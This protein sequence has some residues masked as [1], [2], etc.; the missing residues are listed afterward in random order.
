MLSFIR[1][2]A[3]GWIAWVIVGLLIV[4]FALWGVNEYVG[5]GG[6]LVAA[7]VNG[8]EIGQ[9]EFQQAFYDQRGRMQQMLGGQYD[10]QLFDP[11]IKQRVINELVDRELLLQNADDMGFR[12]S[13]QAVVA[14]IQSIDAFREN[15]V[16]SA[17]LYQQ[18]LQTQGQSPTAFERRV[19][20][21]MT[22]GQLPDGL[23]SSVFVTDAELDAVIKLEKQQRDFQYFVLN[24]S[25][26]QDESLADD[27]AIKDY[28]EQHV[29]R[30]L[31]AEKVRVEY[32]EL[33]ATALKSD[34]EPSEEELREFYDAN[35]GQFSVAEERQASH[36][37]IQLEEGADE[38]AV[39]AAR[40]KAEDL[41]T[42]LKAGESFESLAKE[43]SDDPGSAEMGGDLGYFGRGLMEPD[44]EEVAFS[45]KLGEVSEPVLTPFGY[46]IIKVTGI[47]EKETKPFADVRDEI[48]AQFQ[49]DAA[50]RAYFELAEKLTNQAYEMPDSLSETADELGLE[51]KQSPFFERRG[52]TGVFANPRVVAAAYSDDVLKQGFNSEP[53]EIDE[54]HVLVLRLLD[55]QKADRRP[56][57]EVKA[58]VKQSLI[59]EKAREAVKA[60]GEKALQQ[61]EAGES[62][63]T[64]SKA[65]SVDWKDV[66]AVTRDVK[67]HDAQVVKQAFRLA[68]PSSPDSPRYS[69][70]V[71]NSGDYAVI[72]LNKVVDGDPAAMDAAER[73]TLKR[74]LASE[75]GANAQL[76][77]VSQLKAGA[78][79]IVQNDDL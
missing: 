2:R 70:V 10:A 62:A 37:L 4:P 34:E 32:V 71:L 40:K 38:A 51:L 55:H 76:H 41:V 23:A 78:K 64:V 1:D 27:A 29:D 15:G 53:I 11:Q 35:Q 65:L 49:N 18:Q 43:N 79:V 19:K 5:N 61:L 14:T 57:S 66:G 74:R 33:S 72:Q 9:R 8:T 21:I 69:G 50:E 24:A 28:Y 22:A 6:K 60:A 45:L 47:R 52:G 48:L 16:F 73:E 39:T 25:Q 42:R 77:L 26:F 7:T 67:E 68:R 46:H 63:E 59:Q 13:D 20:R 54:N 30:F 12:V 17:S 44:F 3:Q 58:Q 36:I 56:L 31:T 75:Q